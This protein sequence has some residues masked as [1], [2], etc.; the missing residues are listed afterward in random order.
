MDSV[1]PHPVR[2]AV[3]VHPDDLPVEAW[4]DIVS[5]R[6]MLS[7]DR[8]ATGSLTVGVATLDEGAPINGALHRHAP[9]EVYVILEGEGLVHIGGTAHQVRV[10]S[11]V[12]V[13]GGAW[14]H[15]ENTGTGPLRLL[16]VFAV[17]SFADVIYEYPDDDGQ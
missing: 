7:A 3:V 1:D 13:P 2:P 11:T 4:G 10:G 15:A 8:T 9:D 16:Y 17:D 6:T 12:F 14:H 5:W